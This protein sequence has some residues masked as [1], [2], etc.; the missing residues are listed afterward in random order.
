MKKQ[1]NKDKG[2]PLPLEDLRRCIFMLE[3]DGH[4]KNKIAE[5]LLLTESEVDVIKK[6]IRYTW[7]D[8]KLANIMLERQSNE[9]NNGK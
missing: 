6:Q 8:H 9:A 4:S 7:A 1:E 5:I 3:N 2:L